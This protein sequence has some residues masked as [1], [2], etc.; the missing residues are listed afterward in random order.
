[1]PKETPTIGK[2][3]AMVV[4]SL[5][6]FGL[7]LFLWLSFGGPIPLKPKAYE[8]EVG[9]PEATTLAEEADV[10]ISGVTVGNVKTKELDKGANRTKVKPT[11]AIL[12]RMALTYGRA[13]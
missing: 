13:K 12:W 1:M 7:L 5:T 9:F 10:R 2:M 11:C 3:A 8:L 4:F 6:C